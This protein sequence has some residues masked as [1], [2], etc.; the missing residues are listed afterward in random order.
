MLNKFIEYKF[1]SVSNKFMQVKTSIWEHLQRF[2]F[3]VEDIFM[4]KWN[5]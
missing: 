5:A 1:L 4:N 2:S 3:Q